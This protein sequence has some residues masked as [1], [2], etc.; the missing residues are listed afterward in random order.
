MLLKIPYLAIL[1]ALL[2]SGC[3]SYQFSSNLDKENFDEY[4]KPSQVI[5]Y[6]KSDL[7]DL[8]YQYIGAVEGSSCQEDENQIP[9]NSRDARTKARIN[10]ANMNAN[11][12]VFQSCLD[13]DA[14][15]TCRS[16]VIC[17]GQAITVE[18][19]SGE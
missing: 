13:F 4:F 15:K 12:I 9:A 18:L 17:Y 8:E 11:G 2:L 7:K 6:S 1:S 3:S 10:A 14:D 19:N 16:N 5:V